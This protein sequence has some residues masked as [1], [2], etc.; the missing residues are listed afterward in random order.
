MVGT[1]MW[2]A[3]IFAVAVVTLVSLH[4]PYVNGPAFFPWPW[5]PIPAARIYLSL[6]IAA[7]PFFLAQLLPDRRGTRLA[8][9]LLLMLSCMGLK[10]ASVLFRDDVTPA[11]SPNLQLVQI[12]VEDRDATS[13]YTDAAA[14]HKAGLSLRHWITIY[15]ELMPKLNLHTKSK[16]P[17]P[18][19][20]WWSLV[21]LF[22]AGGRTPLI[23]GIIVG[24]L[25]AL[26]IPATYL[27]LRRLLDNE[28]AAFCGASFLTFCPGFVLF[29]PYFDPAYIL[30][31]SAM[32]GLWYAAMRTDR[33]RWEIL[34]GAVLAVTCFVTFNVLVI[35]LFMAGMV[36][37]GRGLT[38]PRRLLGATKHGAIALATTSLLLLLMLVIFGYDPVSTFKSAWHNQHT[39]LRLHA[40]QR[41]YPQTIPF[42]L[43]DFALGSGWISVLLTVFWIARKDRH[44]ATTADPAAPS[45]SIP[46]PSLVFLSLLQFAAVAALGLLQTETARVW[47]FMLPLLMVPV[48]LELSRWP[49]WE[50]SVVYGCLLAITA[51]VC[52]NVKFVY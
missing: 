30:L 35:G 44:A 43:L 2:I 16:P 12:I 45:L 15:P 50:R 40:D 7:V 8:A 5:R 27:L 13:Y 34:L 25:G 10:V 38:L 51:A 48:G 47:N 18:V 3:V 41:P 1:R 19:L 37:I 33:V 42:D 29:F 52:A 22:G 20:F 4:V 26:S 21:E 28:Q 17:G 11:D 32:I 6:I 49:R 46:A 36:F 23:G 31:S 39:L 9:M 24:A 14:L